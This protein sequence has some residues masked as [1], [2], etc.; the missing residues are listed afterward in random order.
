MFIV[1]KASWYFCSR[2]WLSSCYLVRFVVQLWQDDRWQ[3]HHRPATTNPCLCC[4]ADANEISHWRKLFQCSDVLLGGIYSACCSV[5]LWCCA[6]EKVH[7]FAH[8]ISVFTL[9]YF[10]SHKSFPCYNMQIVTGIE[11]N[12]ETY[13]PK[14]REYS[15]SAE[16]TGAIFPHLREIRLTIDRWWQSLFVS[17]YLW[18]KWRWN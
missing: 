3:W 6:E 5:I 13:F 8:S 4:Y 14:L 17:L 18:S 15:P 10:E 2:L 7:V 9:R 16:G 11:V 1:C 12:S